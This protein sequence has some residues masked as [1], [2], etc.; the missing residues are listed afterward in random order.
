[1]KICFLSPSGFGKSTAIE[2]L[3]KHFDIK[4]I[5]IAEPLYEL[6]NEFYKMLRKSDEGK[7]D[8]ELLQ[9]YGKKVRSVDKNY[10]LNTFKEKVLISN[11]S[12]ITNDDCRPDDY[13]YL[14]S[15]GFIFIK[16]NG[17]KRDRNDL[18]NIDIK[19]KIEWQS[20]IPYDYEIDNY[21]SK[22]EYEKNLL[23]IVRYIISPKCYIIPTQKLCN[24]DCLF[25]IS[26]SRNYNKNK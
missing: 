20:N 8:G 21:G 3:K 4:N 19:N 22:L 18:T 17:F 1:M 16:I 25:C 23:S 11:N 12:I 6:Q 14:K 15:L 10:L 7:Q 5:K 2:I 13:E 26:K 9:F 24:N